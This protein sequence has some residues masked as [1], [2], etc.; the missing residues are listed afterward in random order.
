MSFVRS[1]DCNNKLSSPSAPS[2]ATKIST[3]RKSSSGGASNNSFGLLLPTTSNCVGQTDRFRSL[4]NTKTE[5]PN[6]AWD[7][8]SECK[9]NPMVVQ[10]QGAN[11]HNNPLQGHHS[12]NSSSMSVENGG[13]AMES[14]SPSS[15]TADSNADV[16]SGGD[17]EGVWS[18][19]ID[20]AFHEALQ[21][22]PPCGR[23]KII[24][25]DEGKMYG[26]NELIARYIKIRCGKTRTR[27][28]VS[29]HIQVLARKKQREMGSKVKTQ[30]SKY[31]E[32]EENNHLAAM[33]SL[34]H[35][36]LRHP[37]SH[38]VF[39]RSSGGS[40]GGPLALEVA[41]AAAAANDL[42]AA[43]NGG[44]SGDVR[45]SN[46]GNATN[47]ANALAA[48]AAAGVVGAPGS[49]ASMW[50]YNAATASSV[51]NNY[52]T[53]SMLNDENNIYQHLLTDSP[54][55]TSKLPILS[56]PSTFAPDYTIASSKLILCGFTAYVEQ[57]GEDSNK[58]DLVRIPKVSDEPLE[59]I[60]LEEIQS[61]YPPILQELFKAGPSD[62]F[63]LVKCWANVSFDVTDEQKARFAVDSFYDSS[64][65]CD[66]S[67]STKVC[68]FGN[69]VVEKLR[70]ILQWIPRMVH[71][72][73]CPI[74]RLP[75]L[76]TLST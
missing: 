75:T 9:Y 74:R 57:D 70:S 25:S 67:V 28:Q 24:L 42:L 50:P 68:S 39:S 31:P 35:Q 71:Q 60:K 2:P 6:S 17:A 36:P 49:A 53:A 64:V 38:L 32:D 1:S 13:N 61:K 19:D 12:H 63:F 45:V 20:Q 18:M 29:S 8:L 58:V 48:V 65:N 7:N 51:L 59:I 4:V 37:N 44:A 46:G 54:I 11:F 15:S 30:D 56:Q 14:N 55:A 47:M 10:L 33:N 21:I 66:I 73:V 72:L 26:R 5:S 41:A 40:S 23:R 3:I 43:V 16:G 34:S 52:Y 27:K 22:Y 76:C 62:A 69:Q